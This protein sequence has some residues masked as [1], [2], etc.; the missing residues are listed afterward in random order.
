MTLILIFNF[1]TFL[2]NVTM[3]FY[4]KS[5]GTNENP[6]GISTPGEEIEM[7]QKRAAERASR[8]GVELSPPDAEKFAEQELA[9]YSKDSAKQ[10]LDPE[11]QMKVDEIEKRILDLNPE[12]DKQMDELVLMLTEKGI[13]NTLSVLEKLNNPHLSDDFHRFLI[14]YLAQGMEAC[15]LKE[16]NPLFRALQMKLFEITLPD[17]IGN[18]TNNTERSFASLVTAMEQFYNGMLSI[19]EKARIQSYFTLEIALSNSGD[20]VVIYMAMPKTKVALF[21]KQLLSTFPNASVTEHKE[22]YNPFNKNGVTVASVARLD[23]EEVFPLRSFEK[24]EHDPLNVLLGVFSKLNRE[25]EGAA[26]QLVFAP[27]GDDLNKKYK[28]VLKD[29]KEGVSLKRALES[30]AMRI[31]REWLTSAKD[32]LFGGNKIDL[33]QDETKKAEE[34]EKNK[35][36][37]VDLEAITEKISS[38]IINTNIRII[39]SAD[40]E[41]R[42][43]E[44][45]A[46]LESAFNQFGGGL[47]NS[48]IFNRKSFRELKTVLYE[49]SFRL[50]APKY[51]L[52]LNLKEITTMFHL[53]VSEV[54]ASQLKHS[55]IVS[56]SPPMNIKEEGILL[57]VNR[58]RGTE[59]NIHMTPEDRMRHFYCLGQTGTG[60]TT[61]LKNMI[62]QDIANGEGVCYIDPHGT[63]IEDIINTIPQHRIQDVIYFNP[64][65]AERPMGLNMLEYNPAYPEQ[66]PFVINELLSIFN[67]LFDMKVAGGPM[68]EQYFRN[69]TSLVM[70]D[71]ESGNTLLDVSRVLADA[72]FRELKLSRCKN[73]IVTQFWTE[74][75]AKAGG[76]S[77]LA[78]MVPYITNKFDVFLSNETMRLIVGQ[79][80]SSFNFREVM[81]GRKILLVNLAKGRLGDINSNL[82]GL[83]LVGKILMAALSRVDTIGQQPPDFY[84]YIDEFQNVTTDSISTILSEARKYRLGLIIAHQFISQIDDNIKNA[85]FGNVGSM[86][87]FRVGA[88]DA[89]FLESQFLP[90][91]TAADIMKI[92][93][94]NTY[95]KLLVDGFPAKPFNIEPG[96]TKEGS[97]EFGALI[98]QYSRATYGRDRVQIDKIIM[99]K[100]RNT[101]G[102]GK[103]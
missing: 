47:Q 94:Y 59:T 85:V 103:K 26:I 35:I 75:A 54:N 31:S 29:L 28:G 22:D 7:L 90:T 92:P 91:F 11:F 4:N 95:L 53:P 52:P 101:S 20:D 2:Y 45:V 61:L 33:N 50:F 83:I 32:V 86:S 88:E 14:Q 68:F 19:Q 13:K 84:L 71:P 72:K 97:A 65:D 77:S 56:A 39:G 102:S 10:I 15:G 79:E 34:K 5:L 6:Q 80:K 64:S 46:D 30:T 9:Q 57:G 17:Y 12:E 41:I 100:Y 43:K 8:M 27:V 48:L 42:A 23:K 49:F 62:I 60:K 1:C 69:A 18:N 87:I 25:G 74:I 16:S 70:D 21:E 38:P 67:K 78:N 89:K 81:D 40:T 82:I 36:A 98:K 37:D 3:D 58:H 55:L 93:N 66:K 73:P 44:I 63:D 96:R 76:E 99:D 24:F 51:A